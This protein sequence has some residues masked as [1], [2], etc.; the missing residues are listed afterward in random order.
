MARNKVCA[1]AHA[2]RRRWF[3]STKRTHAAPLLMWA[4]MLVDKSA[5]C[6][7]IPEESEKESVHLDAHAIAV[8]QL[9]R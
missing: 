7:G 5:G 8:L 1:Y 2:R 4:P 6:S 9:K 3:S